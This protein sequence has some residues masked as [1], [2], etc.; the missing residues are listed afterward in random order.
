MAT[1]PG[2]I[3]Y[4]GDYLRDTQCLSERAQVAYDRIMCEHWR[5]I[6]IS[7]QRLKFFTKRLTDDE[8]EEISHVL[9]KIDNG[10]QITWVAESIAK[11]RNFVESRRQSRLKSDEDNVR[12]YIVRDNVR[13]TYKIGSSVNPVRRYNE[14]MNQKNPAIAFDKA[15]SRDYTLVWYSDPVPR[16]EEKKLHEK[17]TYKHLNGEWFA[18]TLDDLSVIF[19]IHSGTTYEK[20]TT[21][22]TVNENVNEDI[23]ENN[24]EGGAGETIA[25]VQPIGVGARIVVVFKEHFPKYPINHSKD[26]TAGYELAKLIAA[27]NGWP[28]ESICNG[29]A[30]DVV[31]EWNKLAAFAAADD[32]YNK[33]SLTFIQSKF[34]DF[35]QAYNGKRTETT[36]RTH[37]QRGPSAADPTAVARHGAGD[38]S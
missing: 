20:R 30:D 28:E 29:R 34:Q 13:S 25:Q 2:F 1:D 4:P 5:E 16:I 23:I 12:I 11:R 36:K 33:K 22:R 8:R 9:T 26:V 24:P 19:S 18:L 21:N 10:Y 35:I 32:W 7:E 17:F 38:F 14:L 27:M 3:F 31:E 6:I 37:Q 15:G